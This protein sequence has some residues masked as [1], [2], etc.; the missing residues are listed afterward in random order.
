MSDRGILGRSELGEQLTEI[1][2]DS[3]LPREEFW[4]Q[5]YKEFMRCHNS[6]VE[7]FEVN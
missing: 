6:D 7:L 3:S 5:S 4:L 2:N 1:C